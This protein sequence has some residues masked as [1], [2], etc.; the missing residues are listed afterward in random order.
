LL[1][2]RNQ[3]REHAYRQGY[4]AFLSDEQESSVSA[5]YSDS[6]LS[7][8]RAA[9]VSKEAERALR[10]SESKKRAAE[11][12]AEKK[13][14]LRLSARKKVWLEC[15]QELKNGYYQ[16]RQF[17]KDALDSKFILKQAQNAQNTE[18][19]QLQFKLLAGLFAR[20]DRDKYP[21]IANILAEH[22][23]T[24]LDGWLK[25]NDEASK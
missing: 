10:L 17:Q 22:G 2:K 12:S 23:I 21:Y 20:M 15:E 1:R 9:R 3:E 14:R 24:T 19:S 11:A 25:L 7:G 16:S 18:V 4:D 6:W 8:H 13:R 5:E